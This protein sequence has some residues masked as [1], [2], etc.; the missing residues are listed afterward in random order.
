[1]ALM[2][3]SKAL[4]V[5]LV[6]LFCVLVGT[7]NIFDYASNYEFVRHVMTMDTTFPNNN[8]MWRSISTAAVHHAVY[9]LIIAGEL[10]AGIL[11]LWGSWNLARNHKRSKQ[12]FLEAKKLAIAGLTLGMVVWFFGFMIV[13]AEWFLMWQSQ[14]WN[15][16]PSAFRFVMCIAVV[17]IYLTQ[18]DPDS[19]G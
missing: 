19:V 11:C 3:L 16:V 13:A 4:L 12:A 6:G 15:G 17:L 8:L 7:N 14:Q 5:F 2:R 18:E 9:W 10:L 1:M